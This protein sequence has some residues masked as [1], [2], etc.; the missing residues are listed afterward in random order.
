M[1]IVDPGLWVALFNNKDRYHQSAQETL[2][3]Y[4]HEPLIT[5]WRVLTETCHLLLQRSLN[6]YQGV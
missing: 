2:A 4:H 1:I 5:T 6:T 3:Q